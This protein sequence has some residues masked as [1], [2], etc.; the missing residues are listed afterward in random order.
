MKRWVNYRKHIVGV[1]FNL[2]IRDKVLIEQALVVESI[3][4]LW[5]HFM[6]TVPLYY[7]CIYVS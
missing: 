3:D 1:E 7:T 4:K 6:V 2:L 5:K